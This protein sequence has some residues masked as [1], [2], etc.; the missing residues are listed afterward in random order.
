MFYVK[1]QTNG[2]KEQEKVEKLLESNNI[3]YEGFNNSYTLLMTEL[4]EEEIYNSRNLLGIEPCDYTDKLNELSNEE[5]NALKDISVSYIECDDI[6]HCDML[7]MVHEKVNKA[8]EDLP[9]LFRYV[10]ELNDK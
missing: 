10:N 2:T 3:R 5:L 8:L 1:I 6:K 7:G 4:V 9:Q